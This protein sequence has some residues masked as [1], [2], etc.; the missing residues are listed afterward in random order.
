MDEIKN[1]IDDVNYPAPK[2]FESSQDYFRERLEYLRKMN[3]DFSV[4]ASCKRLRK[5]S[6]TLVSLILKK[7]RKVT[8][9]RLDEISQLLKLNSEEKYQFK[10]IIEFENDGS[11]IRPATSIKERLKNQLKRVEV[12]Q[13]ILQNPVN[14]YVKDVFQLDKVSRD[15]DKIFEQLSL[16]SKPRKIMQSLKFLLHEGYLRKTIDGRIV[17]ENPL[18]IIEPK[19]ASALVRKFH[20]Q[21]LQ[22]ADEGIEKFTPKQRHANC[23]ILPL[24]EKSY[25]ELVSLIQDFAEKLK[26]FAEKEPEQSDSLYQVIVHLTPTGGPIEV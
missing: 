24:N 20:R 25:E 3:K 7:K 1:S 23:M 19:E 16:V 6:P 22:V 4:T 10:K 14:V 12:S 26:E 8:L 18:S 2:D 15:P 9:D 5:V 17:I 21:A 13:S 11:A